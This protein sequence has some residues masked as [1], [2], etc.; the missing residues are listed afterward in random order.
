MVHAVQK[1]KKGLMENQALL[2]QW[3][4]VVLPEKTEKTERLAPK[5]TPALVD[6]AALVETLVLS[7][8]LDQQALM[9]KMVRTVL[10]D[11]PV[12]RDPKDQS[13]PKEQPGRKV[14]LG[15]PAMPDLVA[16]L[17]SKDR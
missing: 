7:V 8:R 1:E 13:V 12:M 11:Y 16:P 9:E 4:L 17:E 3:D 15:Q 14:K 5:V 6:V 10:M 2:D